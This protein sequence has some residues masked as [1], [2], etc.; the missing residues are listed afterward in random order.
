M[1]SLIK[2]LNKK[3]SN[4]YPLLISEIPTDLS[5]L[6]VFSSL[7]LFL[8]SKKT[9]MTKLLGGAPSRRNHDTGTLTVHT[10]TCGHDQNFRKQDF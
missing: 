8:K 3:K 1:P 7:Y 9:N 5:E 4:V 10:V 6:I 2:C